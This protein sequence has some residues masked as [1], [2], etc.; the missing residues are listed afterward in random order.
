LKMRAEFNVTEDVNVNAIK[1]IKLAVLLIAGFLCFAGLKHYSGSQVYPI[2]A[3]G[4]ICI[5]LLFSLKRNRVIGKVTFGS[6][7]IVIDT[8]KLSTDLPI[9]TIRRIKYYIR[10]Y[11]GKSYVPTL[12]QPIGYRVA[13]GTGNVIEIETEDNNYKLDLSISTSFETKS[14][15]F[16]IK[17]VADSGIKIQEMRLASILGDQI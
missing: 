1:I 11:N 8:N 7:V 10:A 9:S 6:D 2:I 15:E 12:I 5:I 14:I 17:R 16:Q 4:F 3:I 13:H